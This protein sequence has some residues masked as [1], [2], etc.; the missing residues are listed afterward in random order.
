MEKNQNPDESGVNPIPAV[1]ERTAVSSVNAEFLIGNRRGLSLL[2]NQV[3][4]SPALRTMFTRTGGI[5]GDI[6]SRPQSSQSVEA[7]NQLSSLE[8]SI[9]L[10]HI[11]GG[12][13]ENVLTA[14]ESNQDINRIINITTEMASHLD[15][16]CEEI[17]NAIEEL[18]NQTNSLFQR[19]KNLIRAVQ[20]NCSN[21]ITTSQEKLYDFYYKEK[22]LFLHDLRNKEN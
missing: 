16:C 19:T 1:M 9:Y 20:N 11:T 15:N 10:N 13:L 14:Q 12:S 21:L 22:S 5:R 3:N 8:N 4:R 6:L 7:V 2:D 17:K 18:T